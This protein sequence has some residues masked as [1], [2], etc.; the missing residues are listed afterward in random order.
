MLR[1]P[2]VTACRSRRGKGNRAAAAGFMEGESLAHEPPPQVQA[3]AC[4]REQQATGGHGDGQ[5]GVGGWAGALGGRGRVV[6]DEVGRA[7]DF[8][9]LMFVGERL[10]R[11]IVGI[12]GG[13]RRQGLFSSSR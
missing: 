5:R 10:C 7:A 11:H 13:C 12:A 3:T 6:D 2:R 9:H 8:R 4:Q 1:Q